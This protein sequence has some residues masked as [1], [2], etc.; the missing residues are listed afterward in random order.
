MAPSRINHAALWVQDLEAMKAFYVTYFHGVSGGLYINHG[1][2]FRSYFLSFGQGA[3]LELMHM[4]SVDGA[5]GVPNGD[6]LGLAHL[7]FGVGDRDAVDELT[8][9]L[10]KNGFPVVSEPRVTGDGYYESVVLDPEGNR[11]EITE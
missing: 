3:R 11:V 6:R 1:N 7:A 9:Q 10:R 2:G 5:P 4:A 8:E